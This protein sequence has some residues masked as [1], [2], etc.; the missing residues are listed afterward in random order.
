MKKLIFICSLLLST[1]TVFAQNFNFGLQ[2]VTGK[3]VD[4]RGEPLIG[5]SI[6]EKDGK[7]LAT[8]DF[9]GN[10]SIKMQ[11][12]AKA[13][14][15]VSYIGYK[16]EEVKIEGKENI[17]VVLKDDAQLL[18]EMVVI[19]YGTQKRSSLTSSIETINSGDLLKMPVV[20]LDQALVGQVAGLSVMS[21]SGDPS[22]RDAS[23]SIRGISD[24]PLLVIDGIPRF[25]TNTSDSETRLSDLNMD[26]VESISVLKDAAAAA[27]YGARAARGVI[28]VTTKRGKNQSKPRINYRG[29]YNIQK[30]TKFP[31][32]LDAYEYAKL[33]NT[34]LTNSPDFESKFSAYTPE[35]LE[36]IRTNSAPNR[37]GNENLFNYLKD[38]GTSTSH[39]LSISGG[40]QDIRFYFSGGYTNTE[41]LYS[42][43]GRD[44]YNYSLKIDAEVA[45]NLTLTVDAIG[46]R[47]ENKN[48]SY[49]TI[50]A[51]YNFAP[52]QVLQYT[53]G[54]L[55][56]I[57]SSNP[58]ISLKGLGG[59]TKLKTSISTITA[60]L[61]YNLPWVKGL[62][63]YINATF[64]DN[65]MR[66]KTFS[67][68]V[69]LYNFDKTTEII[70][71]DSKTVYPNAKITLQEIANNID[72]KLF[73]IALNYS[74]TFAT[75]HN[76]SGLLLANYQVTDSRS[77]DAT[78][79]NQPGLYP[80]II[81]SGVTDGSINGS[82]GRTER[83]SL[84]GRAT[85]GYDYRYFVETSFR[86]DGSTKF[87]PDNR[88]KFFPS[89]S[90][91]WVTSNELFFKNWDQDL[92]SNLKIR[93]SVGILG[94]DSGLSNFS[95][96]MRYIYAPGS[97]YGFAGSTMRPGVIPSIDAFP[98][99]DIQ[100]EKR[101]VYNLASDLGFWDNRFGVTYE[102]YWRYRTNLLRTLEAYE[103]PP[104]AGSGSRYPYTNGGKVK[105][106]GWDLTI[107]HRNTIGAIKYNADFTI[108]K[109]DNKVLDWG[110][111]SSLPEYRQR[112]G[113]GFL[114]WYLYEADGIFQSW[115]EIEN[116]TFDQDGQ[117]NA[118][119][120][121]GDIRYKNNNGDNKLDSNDKIYVKNSSY[122][123]FN[124]SLKLGVEYKGFYINAMFQGVS[125]YNQQISEI[126]SL[127]SRSLPRFQTYHRDD[128]WTEAN[129]N[130]RYPRIV[131]SSTNGNNRK[132]STF[133]IQECDF[134]RLRSL[135]IGYNVPNCYLQK[136]KISSLNISLQGGN[137]YTW[138]TLKNLDPES[139]RN[140]PIQRTYGASISLGF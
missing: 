15:V 43:V 137:L 103:Y 1:Y 88:W 128:S 100:M 68:P 70:S 90:A 118:T 119:L 122:P 52:T 94:D 124:F 36:M 32:F 107:N 48:T 23:L 5:V 22:G 111:E 50:D 49:G 46:S 6:K 134:I 58:L 126:Y 26:D 24:N 136:M 140:Y 28:L 54:R 113:K 4:S 56:S 13:A 25:G 62:S 3:V 47:S 121:P 61:N 34:A 7:A 65:N 30:A 81:G 77:L 89:L 55:A 16:S 131:F 19:G 135:N 129:P 117:G 76:V 31:E 130:A 35:E 104:S 75:K 60:K 98:N 45:K 69:T 108:S 37:F 40:S 9:D 29:Q 2:D 102:Y 114:T 101:K 116:L 109:T 8:T 110:D 74:N 127:Y 17:H 83:A 14:I 85:Y 112:K 125:G 53:D 38:Q 21:S 39:S 11:V 59:Y 67:T 51:A 42:G 97:G 115:E 132:E 80:E 64:D 10:F 139:L 44:R 27:T 120:A 138:S 72:N 123:D 84:V 86:I 71:E 96:Q 95:Y 12:N 105:E 33:Y 93:S 133:W 66:T 99:I 57:D 18:D 87:H 78:S 79:N 91:S 92:I 20:S 73:D 41:G 63:A 106:W 82:E